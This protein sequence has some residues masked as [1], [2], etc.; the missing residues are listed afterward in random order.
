LCALLARATPTVAAPAIRIRAPCDRTKGEEGRGVAWRELYAIHET[1]DARGYRPR[2]LHGSHIVRRRIS[3]EASARCR[4]W[5][6]APSSKARR[7][8]RRA[9]RL[10]CLLKSEALYP[11]IASGIGR[12][13]SGLDWAPA[14]PASHAPPCFSLRS[15][16]AGLFGLAALEKGS[17]FQSLTEKAQSGDGKIT[18]RIISL[19]G[20]ITGAARSSHV[21]S[22]PPQRSSSV[23]F[24]TNNKQMK[25]NGKRQSILRVADRS[26]QGAERTIARS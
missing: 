3:S 8:T 24:K 23:L 18:G 2:Q 9:G 22:A 15:G 25:Q 13:L 7:R 26:I 6:S 4:I 11:R 12:E 1:L 5:P 19:V 14:A 20:D 16:E 17:W 21:G 10:V